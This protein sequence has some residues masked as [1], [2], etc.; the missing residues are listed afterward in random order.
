LPI[1]RDWANERYGIPKTSCMKIYSEKTFKLFRTK[2][3]EYF[4]K[5]RVSSS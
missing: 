1:C 3:I 5:Q 4:E 2:K